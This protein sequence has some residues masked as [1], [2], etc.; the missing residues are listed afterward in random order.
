MAKKTLYDFRAENGIWRSEVAEKT[1]LDEKM[2]EEAEKQEELSPEIAEKI[3]EAYQL[4]SDY[5]T[6]DPEAKELR[7]TPEKP[8]GYFLNV[9]IIWQVLVCVAYAVITFPT[10]MAGMLET[11]GEEL[12]QMLESIC[13][14]IITAFSGVYLSS[15]IMKKTSYGKEIS[16]YDFIY[17]Y[18]PA[19]ATLFISIITK[20]LPVS[21][22]SNTALLIG[23]TSII[24]V[25]TLFL[26]ALA[27]AFILR[28]RVEGNHKPIKI[29][30][31]LSVVS[32][33]VYIGFYVVISIMSKTEL[34]PFKVGILILEF[35][36]MLAVI[37][38][39]LVGDK[40]MPKLNK[41]WLVVLPI[42]AMT[43]PTI[44]SAIYNF[45]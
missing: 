32:W 24:A 20:L 38:G 5:F 1:G 21:F 6:F 33:F 30:S 44:I 27:T 28:G 22:S 26:Q 2:L 18:L 43:L 17:P 25:V 41:L 11:A 9:V 45:I 23:S 12:F 19:Q 8:F 10:M 31:V 29:V 16:H 14:V 3:V 35:V 39:V 13:Q 15:Y 42:C 40:K 4:S 37:F 7:Y 36:L 34:S